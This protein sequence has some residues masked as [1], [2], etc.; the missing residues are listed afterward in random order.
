MGADVLVG[1]VM[2][3]KRC[4]EKRKIRVRELRKAGGQGRLLGGGDFG[5]EGEEMSP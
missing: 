5:A 2:S 1:W 4:L 3:G